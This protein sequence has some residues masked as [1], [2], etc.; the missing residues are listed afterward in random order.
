MSLACV[1]TLSFSIDSEC[2][3]QSFAFSPDG[4]WLAVG[5][6]FGDIDIYST[7]KN[8]RPQ[9]H[10]SV[11]ND[12]FNAVAVTF[13]EWTIFSWLTSSAI[14]RPDNGVVA[15]FEDGHIRIV[16]SPAESSL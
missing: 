4:D 8:K 3:P 14:H 6:S 1:S 5:T 16:E 9:S 7:I 15:A 11:D 13:I 12:V 2:W 10:L